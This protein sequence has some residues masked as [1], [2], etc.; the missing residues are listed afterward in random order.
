[1]SLIITAVG[2]D[3]DNCAHWHSVYPSRIVM[4]RNVNILFSFSFFVMM[5]DNV[6]FLY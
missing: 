1:M 6:L 2:K 4:I 3:D 5:P